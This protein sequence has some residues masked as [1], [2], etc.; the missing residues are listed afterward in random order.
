MSLAPAMMIAALLVGGLGVAILGSIKV[1]LAGRLAIDEAKVGG[2]VSIFGFAMIPAMLVIGFLTDQ[3]DKRL[4]LI[5]GLVLIAG[6]MAILGLAK[7][8]ATSLAAVLL[9]STGWSLLINVGNVLVPSA[10]GGTKAYANNLANVFFGL[11]AFLTPLAVTG[12]LRRLSFAGTL[13]LLALLTLVPALLAL[14]VDFTRLA[15]PTEATEPA[16]VSVLLTAPI[17]WLCGF[18]LFFYGPMEACLAAWTTTYLQD[19]GVAEATA[20][21]VLSTF[22]LTYMAARLGT[23]FLLPA[24]AERMFILILGVICIVLLAMMVRSRQPTQSMILVALAGLAFGPIFPTLIAVLLGELPQELWGR[25]VGLFFAIG[26]VGWTI[27][28]ILIA[29]YAR[30]AKLQRAFGIVAAAATGL[31]GV[32]MALVL[33]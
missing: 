21:K 33:K 30:R 13:T 4:I 9:F 17:L 10:F 19:Q 6:S 7:R 11:G 3:V 24:G 32:A 27:L 15:P 29:N 2:L 20:A 1:P 22:W 26:G 28:P 18:G 31:S 16:S 25:A 14:G 12:M 5:T 23:A 8:Y